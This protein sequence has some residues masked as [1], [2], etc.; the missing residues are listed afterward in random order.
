MSLLSSGAGGGGGGSRSRGYIVPPICLL[1]YYFQFYFFFVCSVEATKAKT[2]FKNNKT[3]T[4]CHFHSDRHI[5]G[6]QCVV[7]SAK[8]HSTNWAIN[9]INENC[10]ALYPCLWT[11][12]ANVPRLH[13][14]QTAFSR[15]KLKIFFMLCLLF[16]KFWVET[17]K[18]KQH[19]QCGGL[20][21]VVVVG[22]AGISSEI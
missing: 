19:Q 21:L 7:I 15:C 14:K 1:F 2:S 4:S 18:Y 12:K 16:T 8:P 11:T 10:T 3:F 5:N 13:Q 17:K 6:Q 9:G 20:L 22:I